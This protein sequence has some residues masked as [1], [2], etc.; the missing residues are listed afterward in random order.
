MPHIGGIKTKL[1]P[2][3]PINSILYL[4]TIDMNPITVIDFV[5]YSIACPFVL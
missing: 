1:K 4:I 3:D 2:G 5:V